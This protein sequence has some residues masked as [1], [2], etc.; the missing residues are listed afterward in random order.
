MNRPQEIIITG[1]N[2]GLARA[3]AARF[4]D[5]GW[6]VD[7]PGRAVLDVTDTEAV[8]SYFANRAPDLLVCN[9]GVTRDMPLAR[10]AASDWQNVMDVNFHG[11]RRCA[12]ACLAAMVARGG[13]HVVF[14]SSF[15]ALHPPAGQAAYAVAKAA[16]I[17]LAQELASEV[18]GHGIRVNVVLP[19]FLETPMTREVSTARR[20][21]ILAAH[22]LGRFNTPKAVAAFLWH[23]HHDLPHTSGQVFQLDSRVG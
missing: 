20:A 9:A 1:G 6:R 16:L 7:A 12:A 4:A 17:G 5:G 23:L 19:G 22:T 8:R 15:S 18:G 14:L 13:G 3:I 10:L 11:A 2:G 21:E